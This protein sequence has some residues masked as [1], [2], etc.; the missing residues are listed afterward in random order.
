MIIGPESGVVPAPTANSMEIRVTYIRT[1]VSSPE[2]GKIDEAV[3]TLAKRRIEAESL[4]SGYRIVV[5]TLPA[6][7]CTIRA[8]LAQVVKNMQLI[9]DTHG[10]MGGGCDEVCDALLPLAEG[11]QSVVVGYLCETDT[12]RNRKSNAMFM[13]TAH[14]RTTIG[15]AYLSILNHFKWMGGKVAIVFG[16]DSHSYDVAKSIEKTLLNAADGN[17]T[18]EMI[19][20]SIRMARNRS[21]SNTSNNKTNRKSKFCEKR[22]IDFRGRA[23]CEYNII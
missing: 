7:N 4:L 8:V 18:V 2:D 10:I 11:T 22:F 16:T 13:T 6:G 21:K 15:E 3:F 5:D 17:Y 20:Y 1:R 19:L 23:Q 14:I 12:I 9:T